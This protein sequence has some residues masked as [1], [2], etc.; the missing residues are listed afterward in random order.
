MPLECD[1]Y[2]LDSEHNTYGKEEQPIDVT[3]II[4]LKTNNDFLSHMF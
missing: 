1:L 3:E 2:E 4:H